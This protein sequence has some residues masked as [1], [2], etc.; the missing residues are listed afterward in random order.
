MNHI[1]NYS[2]SRSDCYAHKLILKCS[3]KNWAVYRASSL[4]DYSL[5]ILV[6]GLLFTTESSVCEYISCISISSH[7]GMTKPFQHFLEFPLAFYHA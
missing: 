6:I 7:K 2:I 1:L 3:N 5:D 4:H